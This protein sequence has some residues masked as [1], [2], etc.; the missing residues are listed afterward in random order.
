MSSNPQ[1]AP[2]YWKIYLQLVND[3]SS[4]DSFF[5]G[6]KQIRNSEDKIVS[7][8]FTTKRDMSKYQ[9]QVQ[10]NNNKNKSP[11]YNT[12]QEFETEGSMVS[13]QTT[14]IKQK[15]DYCHFQTLALPQLQPFNSNVNYDIPK[16][17]GT[18][19]S[20][21]S[22]YYVSVITIGSDF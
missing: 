3:V 20:M 6:L 5:Y 21:G 1:K 10:D 2:C 8:K 15:T 18:E 9:T 13:K 17:R 14:P 22:T 19:A 16:L 4:Q 11:R 12:S 7:R